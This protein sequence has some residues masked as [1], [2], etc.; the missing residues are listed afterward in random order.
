MAG[1]EREQSYWS[2]T[3]DAPH[4]FVAATCVFIVSGYGA[5]LAEALQDILKEL[6]GGEDTVKVG[7]HLV[8]NINITEVQKLLVAVDGNEAV[9]TAWQMEHYKDEALG[10]TWFN[11]I[12]LRYTPYTYNWSDESIEG[13]LQA[14]G[15]D[16]DNPIILGFIH[17]YHNWLKQP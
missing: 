9:K 15:G 8:F 5:G 12:V 14:F 1:V 3:L 16:L 6:A 7:S 10:L 11:D 17:H 2:Y 13:T 4:D